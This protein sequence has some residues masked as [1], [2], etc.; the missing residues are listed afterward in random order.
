MKPPTIY[1]KP[2]CGSTS[3]AR[4]AK[5]LQLAEEVCQDLRHQLTARVVDQDWSNICKR[6]HKWMQY[7][8]KT[9]K[10]TNPN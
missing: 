8:P 6:L 9:I 5:R 2:F 3:Q 7:A 4:Q 10:Y 1:D